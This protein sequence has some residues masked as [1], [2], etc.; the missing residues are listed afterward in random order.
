MKIINN[1]KIFELTYR[2]FTN[3]GKTLGETIVTTSIREFQNL[4]KITSLSVYPLEYHATKNKIVSE[5]IKRGRKFISLN[6]IQ[7]RTYKGMA[8]YKIKKEI[9][10]FPM[11]NRVMV[12]AISFKEKN[13]DYFFPT[14]NKRPSEDINLNI[15]LYNPPIHFPD[16]KDGSSR[17]NGKITKPKTFY[18]D[19]DLLLC[20]PT[21]FDFSLSIKY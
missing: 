16:S 3:D 18:T 13:P 8:F 12:D 6:E 17:N 20:K 2:Y 21:I 10:K 4:M 14:V 5:L 15:N 1:E 19:E 7:Y 11:D 9:K